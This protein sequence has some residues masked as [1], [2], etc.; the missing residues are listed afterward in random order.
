MPRKIGTGIGVLLAVTGLALSAF[1][2]GGAGT[3]YGGE[4]GDGTPTVAA[5]D[6][7]GTP[8]AGGAEGTSTPGPL[9]PVATPTA[10]GGA[11]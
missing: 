11:G 2:L 4:N 7:T 9:T 5:G 6:T 10:G 1:A 3:A 8:A